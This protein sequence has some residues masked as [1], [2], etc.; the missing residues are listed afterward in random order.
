MAAAKWIHGRGLSPQMRSSKPAVAGDSIKPGVER[1][2]TPG[3]VEE[4][5]KVRE[6]ADSGINASC[7][8]IRYRPLRGLQF[9]LVGDPGVP[10]RSTPGSMLSAASRALSNL[11]HAPSQGY[12]SQPR[13]ESGLRR[14]CDSLPF[15]ATPSGL[16]S[17]LIGA[18]GPGL[19][20]PNASTPRGLP[21]RG[22]RL[23]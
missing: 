5:I 22:P 19:P 17:I 2:G 1:S 7:C 18:V 11:V 15:D 23:G 6:A 20:K 4:I 10:L 12:L 21:A 16:R 3:S 14:F 13:P 8:R 9:L